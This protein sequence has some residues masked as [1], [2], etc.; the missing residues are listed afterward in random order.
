MAEKFETPIPVS[1]DAISMSE[2]RAGEVP[3]ETSLDLSEKYA[4]NKLLD[5][6]WAGGRSKNL[7]VHAV[8]QRILKEQFCFYT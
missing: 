8:M 3:W 7:G 4:I 2:L 6:R 5:C 1:L